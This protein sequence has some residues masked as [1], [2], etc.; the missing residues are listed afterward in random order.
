MIVLTDKAE[1]QF[2]INLFR[3][4]WTVNTFTV[5]RCI[6]LIKLY[7]YIQIENVV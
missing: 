5:Q 1:F 7:I 2:E 4:R 3:M 6:G